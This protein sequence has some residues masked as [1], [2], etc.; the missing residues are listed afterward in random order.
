MKRIV[1][2]G[3]SPTAHPDAG[4]LKP[5]VN[6]IV[7]DALAD[8][9]LEAGRA[10]GDFKLAEEEPPSAPRRGRKEREE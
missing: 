2:T 1:F 6:E 9:L 7:D 10:T 8:R 3:T 4:I 5:G